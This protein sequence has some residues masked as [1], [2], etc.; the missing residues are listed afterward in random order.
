M[1]TEVPLLNPIIETAIKPEASKSR[2]KSAFKVI[3]ETAN[4]PKASKSRPKSAYEV[5]RSERPDLL[6]NFEQEALEKHPDNLELRKGLVKKLY[7]EFAE[8][9]KEHRR[10]R[11]KVINEESEQAYKILDVVDERPS[12]M[13]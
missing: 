12:R 3:I 2:P 1:K 6:A 10:E 7:S 13:K 9:D 5:A 8:E 11:A 4:D